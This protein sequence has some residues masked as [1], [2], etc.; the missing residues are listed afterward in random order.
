MGRTLMPGLVMLVT[1]AV[2]SL[3]LALPI[4]SP[5]RAAR[6]SQTVQDLPAVT[7]DALDADRWS[8]G[9][10]I[11]VPGQ[12]LSVTNRGVEQDTFTVPAW[13]LNVLLPSLQPIEIAVPG[14]ARPGD[15]VAFWCS[16]ANHRE[17]GQQGTVTV[18]GEDDLRTR[19]D[20]QSSLSIPV[21]DRVVVETRDDFQFVPAMLEAMPGGLIEVRNNGVLEHHFVVDEWGVNETI[22]PGTSP[23]C[24]CRPISVPATVTP[25]PARFRA[26]RHPAWRARSSSRRRRAS[27]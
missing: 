17:N 24:R 6:V 3:P 12:T 16:I 22:A 19:F 27:S 26:T 9:E 11:A 1:V 23:S 10:V 25:F 4:P 21:Q 14:D 15:G 2:L 18:V 7:I 8:I 20:A 5:A 13:G